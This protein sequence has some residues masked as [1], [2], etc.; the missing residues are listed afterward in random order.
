[1]QNKNIRSPLTHKFS[2]MG[3]MY[4]R[5]INLPEYEN[6]TAVERAEKL[7]AMY[8]EWESAPNMPERERFSGA[9]EERLNKMER[10]IWTFEQ[11]ERH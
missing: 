10:V 11:E 9:R 1:M 4:K 5:L 6:L 2:W 3:Y 7:L 8:E